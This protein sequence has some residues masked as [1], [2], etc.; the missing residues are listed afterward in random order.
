[1]DSRAW[2]RHIVEK[3]VECRVGE[4]IGTVF[5]YNLSVGGGMLDVEQLPMAL[6]DAV[7]VSFGGIQRTT[8]QVVW[9]HDG[10]A[11]VRFDTP[12]HE[13][14]VRHLGFNPPE[15]DFEAQAPRD[16]FGRVL[17]PIDAGER[18]VLY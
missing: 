8:G 18:P 9:A 1:M 4:R 17:P 10:C 6:G 3:K 5:L 12:L 2:D 11:G 14:V 13:A 15:L 16:R 7:E